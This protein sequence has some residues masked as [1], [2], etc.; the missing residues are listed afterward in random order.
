MTV[1][2]TLLGKGAALT[3]AVHTLYTVP[4]GKRTILKSITLW[5]N[6]A[7]TNR[8]VVELT[9]GGVTV[10]VLDPVL[11]ATGSAGDSFIAAPWI[12]LNAGD[13]I[14][15]APQSHPAD[16]TLSGAELSLT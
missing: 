9:L 3:V 13:L 12:V 4:S 8:V 16:C 11:A 1:H 7:A 6:F 15:V 2:S 10:V 14:Q 5:N